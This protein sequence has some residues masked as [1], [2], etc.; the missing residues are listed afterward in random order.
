MTEV[1]KT[2]KTVT[3]RD[4]DPAQIAFFGNIF[5][6]S[7]DAFEAFVAASHIGWEAYFHRKDVMMPIRHTEA[8]YHQPFFPGETYTVEVWI[9]RIG[10]HSFVSAYKYLS[11]KGS[12]AE[13][14]IVHAMM[15]PQ[16][17]KK[18]QVPQDLITQLKP[19]VREGITD[20]QN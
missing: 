2:T 10:Q 15:D 11:A 3:F 4:A 17:L 13:V 5:A 6:W 7:H 14:K 12:H 19:Y 16:T 9:D 18:A 1:F 20:E 8:T